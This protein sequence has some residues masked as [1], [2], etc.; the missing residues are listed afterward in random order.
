MKKLILVLA[1]LLTTIVSGQVIKANVFGAIHMTTAQRDSFSPGTDIAWQIYNTDNNRYEYWNG[2][3]WVE[4]QGGGGGLSGFEMNYIGG[5]DASVGADISGDGFYSVRQITATGTNLPLN[6]AI[7]NSTLYQG[8][9]IIKLAN[10]IWYKLSCTAFGDDSFRLFDNDMS[11]RTAKFDLSGISNGTERT[12]TIQNRSGTVAYLDDVSGGTQDLQSVTD[13]GTD[14]N[15]N[16]RILGTNTSFLQVADL[17]N[18]QTSVLYPNSILYTNSGGSL[19]VTIPTLTAPRTLTWPD[20]S[21]T[22]ATLS[23]VSGVVGT[24][25]QVLDAGDTAN[26]SINLTN[27]TNLGLTVTNSTSGA[28]ATYQNDASYFYNSG[29]ELG[30]AP[31]TLTDDH[32]INWPDNSGTVA[33]LSDVTNSLNLQG[34]TDNGAT[35]TTPI[36]TQSLKE[37]VGNGNVSLVT[38][39]EMFFRLNSG[40][41][42]SF[43]GSGSE[44]VFNTSR[45]TGIDKTTYL[46]NVNLATFGVFGGSWDATANTFSNTDTGKAGA[47]WLVTVGGSVDFGAGSITFSVGDILSNDGSVYFKKV[48]NNQSSGSIGS[49]IT[50]IANIAA[51]RAFT[52][53]PADNSLFYL[54]GYY[55]YDDGGEGLFRWYGFA[56]NNDDNGRVIK[57]TSISTG[58][59]IRVVKN[60][61]LSIEQ[62]GART[63]AANDNTID[64][65]QA[66]LDCLDS[67]IFLGGGTLI[68]PD[69]NDRF[70]ITLNE[71]NSQRDYSNIHV[72]GGGKIYIDWENSN[73]TVAQGRGSMFVLG[74]STDNWKV[75]NLD[76]FVHEDTFNNNFNYGFIC[77]PSANSNWSKIELENVKCHSGV[78]P[79]SATGIH[80]LTFPRTTDS[81]DVGE[82]SDFIMRDCDILLYGK[83]NYGVHLQRK[84]TNVLFENNKVIL[85]ASTSDINDSYNAFAPYGGGQYA[86]FIGNKCQSG[87]G[88]IG[89]SGFEDVY[90]VGNDVTGSS[91][92][93][94]GGIEV[95]YK[96]GHH[97]SNFQTRNVYIAG[98]TVRNAYWGIYVTERA[99]SSTSLAPVNVKIINNTTYNSENIDIGV[100][101]ATADV[102]G[103]DYTTRIKNV[104]IDGN[105]MY[106]S[107]TTPS[108]IYIYDSDGSKVINNYGETGGQY[109]LKYGRTATI[110]P[111][112]NHTAKNN[113]FH[114]AT[115]ACIAI[116]TS[117]A[118]TNWTFDYNILYPSSSARGIQSL[119]G[120]LVNNT[121]LI[122]YNKVYGGTDGYRVVSGT[123]NQY[124][125]NFAKDCSGY[126]FRFNAG[127]DATSRDN[128]SVNC[129]TADQFTGTNH[130][131]DNNRDL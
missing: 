66:Y 69:R 90:I 42:F 91:V 20:K 110:S 37:S 128:T 36:T 76:F 102:S 121:F 55:D 10:A 17:G 81:A 63:N 79:D 21:G 12:L 31:P 101:T 2:S 118:N 127:T 113:E 71:V 104:L 106:S 59:F 49:D 75:S 3:A 32:F 95:E 50:T 67:I 28:Y 119:G 108:N 82:G 62:F 53:P 34:V 111:I 30:I 98:N 25:Q 26:R 78:E 87:H 88:V 109:N 72:T 52:T 4:F 38:N 122:N 74:T 16:I 13:Q 99:P 115:L 5:Y 61:E 86:K 54:Q 130:T 27:T 68:I 9:Y 80:F 39:N 126:G 77:M 24:L 18:N 47:E 83:S 117:G 125:G 129:A 56:V 103:P 1:L 85:V 41:Y 120:G 73:Q 64:S 46:P 14:T 11:N 114:G 124:V 22:I 23:D 107:S 44:H 123:Y 70:Y 57:A 97:D 48:D 15:N 7:A 93:I 58:R 35:T 100:F 131:K 89:V 116:E 92:Q 96:N 43:V 94:E 8:E 65:S 40:D 45:V 51:M 33:L 19:N 105:H 112:G 60:R 84:A 29:F 6:N